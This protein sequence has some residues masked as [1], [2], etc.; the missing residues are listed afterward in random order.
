MK[1]S[2]K[3]FENDLDRFCLWALVGIYLIDNFDSFISGLRD[4]FQSILF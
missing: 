3:Y 2:I 1:K 4:G